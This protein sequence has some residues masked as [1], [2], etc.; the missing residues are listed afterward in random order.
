MG[1]FA[2]NHGNLGRKPLVPQTT[3]LEILVLSIHI[4]SLGNQGPNV[5]LIHSIHAN[6]FTPFTR[7]VAANSGVMINGLRQFY[8]HLEK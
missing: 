7:I 8:G 2:G 1:K 3:D 4:T 5:S 6:T